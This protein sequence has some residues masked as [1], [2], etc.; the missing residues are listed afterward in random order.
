[1]S[2]QTGASNN[3][4]KGHHVE[5]GEPIDSVLDVARRE[6]EDHCLQGFQLYHSLGGIGFGMGT[7]ED[8]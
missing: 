2:G 5:S 4:M 6:T 7:A 1:M 8:P 3:R